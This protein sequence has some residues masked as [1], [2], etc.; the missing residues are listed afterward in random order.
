VRF[1]LDQG[2]E[3]FLELG[4]GNTL[5]KLIDAIRREHRPGPPHAVH[6]SRTS[7]LPSAAGKARIAANALGSAEFRAD[8]RAALAYTVAAADHGVTSTDLV[9]RC[10]KAGILSFFGPRGLP[11]ERVATAL[12]ELQARLG[13]GE[14]F[15]VGVRSHVANPRIDHDLI[16]LCMQ[17][18]ITDIEASGY[19]HVSSDLVRYRFHDLRPR[20]GNRRSEPR[21]IARVSRPEMARAF[22]SP[23]PERLL[24]AMVAAGEIDQG[25]ADVARREPLAWDICV[26]ADCGGPTDMGVALAS[27]PVICRLRDRVTAEFG[28]ARRIRVGLAGGIG[29]P[30]AAAAAFLMGADFVMTGSIN[31]CTL[32][33][34]TSN[35]VKDMLQDAD[36]QDTAYAPAADL[37]E[38][39]GRVRVLKKG[40]FFAARAEKL[41]HLFLSH[42]SLEQLPATTRRQIEE[43]YFGR[44]LDDVWSEVSAD[45]ARQRQA[46]GGDAELSPKQRMASVFRRYCEQGTR[47]ALEGRID[48]RV[49]YQV[50]CGPAMGACNQWLG[51]S[52]LRSWRQRHADEIGAA[53]MEEA[54]MLLADRLQ[55]WAS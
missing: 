9:V 17:R 30:P 8:H 10:G 34:A 43:H 22:M 32:E 55:A 18:G 14:P 44:S 54:A 5:T 41:F 1:L 38:F 3:Q 13:H 24:Q 12:D 33:A 11:I 53:M 19:L 21:L 36:V 15:G 2:V 6:E 29:A 7:E 4:P 48:Q 27:L 28:Y 52:A 25:A 23:A 40:V 47:L 50:P 46:H 39:G 51:Q 45:Q 20:D 49:N 42:D 31:Q 16:A 35:N 37:F 26:E